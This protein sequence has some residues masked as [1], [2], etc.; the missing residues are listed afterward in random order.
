MQEWML[1]LKLMYMDA[2]DSRE[3]PETTW[4]N[5]RFFYMYIYYAHIYIVNNI[6]L[7]L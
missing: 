2:S 3:V 1:R 5:T 4:E 7:T 6:L